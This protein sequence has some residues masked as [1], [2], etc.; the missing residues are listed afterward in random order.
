MEWYTPPEIIEAA[1]RVMG[2]IDCDPC[3]SI[4][5]HTGAKT[6]YT[7]DTDG[8][9]KPWRGRVWLNPPYGQGLAR[10]M[11]RANRELSMGRTRQ[12]ICL[13]PVRTGA[14]WFHTLCGKGASLCFPRP[15][16]FVNG[17]TGEQKGTAL[18]P[19][20]IVY[21]GPRHKEFAQQFAQFGLVTP[22]LP[23]LEQQHPVQH[24]VVD[25]ECL[26]QIAQDSFRSIEMLHPDVPDEGS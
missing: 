26:A 14:G 9:D 15:L 24:N 19:S 17:L 6:F 8:L 13:I 22:P 25:R 11:H 1:R 23:E 2:A 21:V 4:S 7:A 20:V 3:T 16:K 12:I 5:N 18:M 10:W